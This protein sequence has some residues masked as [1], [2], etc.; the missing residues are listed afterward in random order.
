MY[1]FDGDWGNDAYWG[2]FAP[3]DYF[4]RYDAR[5]LDVEPGPA[6]I[7]SNAGRR[8]STGW[9]ASMRCGSMRTTQQRDEFAGELLR[10][11]LATQL[12]GD[13]P[14]LPTAKPSG[15]LSDRLS[16]TAG[17][18]VETRSADYSDSDGARFDPRDSMV[19][20]QVSLQ[21]PLGESNRGTP[22]WRAATRRAASTSA[23]FVPDESARSSTPEYLWNAES[24]LR[25]GNAAA[26]RAGAMSRSSTCGARTSRWRR[27][28][29]SIRAIRCRTS[30]ITDNAAQAAA[31][32]DSKPRS[33]WQPVERLNSRCD[34]GVAAVRIRR[35]PLR[36]SQSRRPGAGACTGVPVLA[37]RAVGRRAKGGWRAR[38]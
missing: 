20:G 38:T 37:V 14:A 10:P 8:S 28:S 9:P 2:E 27:R 6:R 26:G 3:Y 11:L 29:S 16:L 24:G 4:S 31:T 19:G 17:L 12:R 18:R 35:L 34:A 30:S 22:R 23:Q 36:R 13:Q 1:S 7:E 15:A 5:A 33:T 21:G 32:T 25:F